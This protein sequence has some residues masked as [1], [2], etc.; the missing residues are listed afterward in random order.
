MKEGQGK[1]GRR[2]EKEGKRKEGGGDG[3]TEK[4]RT[5]PRDDR[6]VTRLDLT[7]GKGSAERQG[8]TEGG[9]EEGR[10]EVRKDR[11]ERRRQGGK[12]GRY[13]R[14][15]GLRKKGRKRETEG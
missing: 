4:G 11:K 15:Q 2:A 14:Y 10:K 13:G 12:D 3:E 1:E 5:G 9:R 7:R 8:G 6:V